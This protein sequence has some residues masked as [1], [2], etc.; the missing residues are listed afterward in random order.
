[1]RRVPSR[2]SRRRQGWHRGW[3]AYP[4]RRPGSGR[5]CPRTSAAAAVPTPA[6]GHGS[7]ARARPAGATAGT[8]ARR[9]PGRRM[10]PSGPATARPA[11]GRAPVPAPRH[12]SRS[13]R[14]APSP[15]SSAPP[16]AGRG[17]APAPSAGRKQG[18]CR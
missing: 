3:P 6:A 7:A 8:A 10:H 1:M 17:S 4:G 18:P 14:P 5:D 15:G 9:W 16:A 12:R 2:R 13:S 11:A